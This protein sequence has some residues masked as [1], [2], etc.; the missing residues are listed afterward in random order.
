MKSHGYLFF[1]TGI[2]GCACAGTRPATLA[3]PNAIPA[4]NR[5]SLTRDSG[6]KRVASMVGIVVDSAARSPVQGATVLLRS[7]NIPKPYFAYTDERG[8]FVIGRVQPDVYDVLV[9]RVGYHPH[10]ERRTLRANTVDTLRVRL[11]VD[12]RTLS[13]SAANPRSED[14]Q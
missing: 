8:G 11:A 1:A 7:A 14:Q 2:I 5:D 12:T 10:T 4:F 9:R 13:M 6:G 3:V